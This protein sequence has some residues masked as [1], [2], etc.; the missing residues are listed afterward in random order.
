MKNKL[1]K[2]LTIGFCIF[3]GI[4]TAQA[5]T[6]SRE[7]MKN[8]VLVAGYTGV[9][10]FPAVVVAG[11]KD[12]VIEDKKAVEKIYLLNASPNGWQKSEIN[13]VRGISMAADG[14]IWLVT[15][16]HSNPGSDCVSAYDLSYRTC[17]QF[18]KKSFLLE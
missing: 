12:V 4:G 7:E 11:P 13:C 10:A 15:N 2:I 8:L 18:N 17:L 3:I 5:Q 14:K 16:E 1:V 6:V 9:G